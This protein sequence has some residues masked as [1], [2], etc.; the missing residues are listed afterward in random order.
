SHGFADQRYGVSLLLQKSSL[1]GGHTSRTIQPSQSPLAMSPGIDISI[2]RAVRGR[3]AIRVA[4][5]RCQSRRLGA[6]IEVGRW[7]GQSR[8]V[9]NLL[10]N[11]FAFQRLFLASAKR[12]SLVNSRAGRSRLDVEAQDILVVIRAVG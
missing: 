2:G 11:R 10:P 4:R 8:A 6:A 12:S 3:G 7:I 9:N 5:A 1:R